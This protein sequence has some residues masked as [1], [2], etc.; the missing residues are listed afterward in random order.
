MIFKQDSVASLFGINNSVSIEPFKEAANVIDSYNEHIKNNT[1]TAENWNTILNQCDDTLAEH[2]EHIK[3]FE[4]T[5]TGYT[6]SLQGGIVG[7]NKVNAAIQQYNSL[8][9]SS[10]NEQQDLINT[11]TVTNSKLGV[12]LSGLNGANAS[13]AGYGLSLLTSTAKT[14]GLTIATTALNAALTMGISVIVTGAITAFTSWINASK[15]ITKNAQAA[16]DKIAS[17]TSDL[18]A[19]TETVENSK[20]RYA[21]L[22][23]E[24]ENLG[25]V[26]QSQGNLS[27]DEYKEFLDISNQL[28]GVF[29]SLTKGYDDNGNAILDLSGNVDTIVGSLDDLLQKEKELANKQIIDQI[30]NVYKDYDKNVKN[31]TQNVKIAQDQFDRINEAYSNLDHGQSIQM[32][33][34][35]SG[36]NKDSGI[37]IGQYEAW[38]DSLGLVYKETIV[39]G[40]RIVSAV[41]D[42]DQAF[43][44][45]LESARSELQYAKQQLDAE[46][47]S[48]GSYLNTWL[49]SDFSYNQI[50][51][52]GL[53]TAVKDIITNFD[54]TNLP[55]DVDSK[56]WDDVSEYLK[57][58]II[59]AISNLQNNPEIANALSQ[60]FTNTELMPDEKDAYL[61]KIT[62]YFGENNPVTSS[63]QPQV[64]EVSRL[65]AAYDGLISEFDDQS[66]LKRFLESNSINTQEEI[67]Y[68]KKVTK[69]AKTTTEAIRAYTKA[70]DASNKKPFSTSEM[71]SGINGLSEGFEELDKIMTSMK[72]KDKKFDYSLLDDKKFKDN[73][74]GYTKE[75]DTFIKTITKN[76]KDIKA[77]Q[78]AFDNLANAFV[79]GS[80]VMEHLSDDNA[81]VAKQYLELMGIQNADEVVTA[82]LAQRHAE[83]A[84]DSQDLTN[85]TYDEIV[86]L[87]KEKESTEAG[88]KAFELYIAQKLLSNAAIDPTGDI[89]ALVS[90]IE[91]LG[92][93]S[94]AWKNYYAAKREQESLSSAEIITGV[95]G[96]QIKKVTT[97]D[98]GN[99]L[100]HRDG[101]YYSADGTEY[102]GSTKSN[103]YSQKS[104]NWLDQKTDVYYE[105]VAKELEAKAKNVQVSNYT[106]PKSTN[107]QKGSKGSK[108]AKENSTID[109]IKRSAELLERESTRLQTAIDDTWQ[110][111]T[112]LSQADIERVQEL[113]NMN[114]APNSDEVN[115]LLDYADKL[116]VSIGELQNLANNNG[117]ESRQSLLEQLIDVDKQRLDQGIDSLNYYKNSYE[118]YVAKVPEYRDKIENGGIDIES[119]S[120]DEKTNIENAMNAYNSYL[121]Q[122]KTNLELS[123]TIRDNELKY[124]TIAIDEID[125]K[126]ARLSNSNDLIQK[127]I[128]LLNTQGVTVSSS[129]Y[130]QLISNTEGQIGY[131]QE[132]LQKQKDQ[133]VKAITEEDLKVGSDKWYELNDEI[134]STE[135]SIKDLEKAQAEYEKQLRELPI[136]NLE[137]LGTIYQNI[138]D[139]IQNWGSEMEASGKKLNADY[140]QKLINSADESISNYK[141]E[142]EAIQD[143]MSDYDPGTDNWNEMNDKLQQCNSSISSLVQNMH[144]WNEELL[145]LPIDKI[146]DAS[147]SLSKIV[148]GLND[149]KSEHETVIS[150]VTGAISDEIDRLNDEKEAYE[151]TINDQKEALQDRMDL[152]D[153]QNEKLKLQAQYE[154]ALY[155]LEN[156]TTQK[157]E[158]VIRNGEIT[159]ESN[160]DNLR[161]AQESV[162]DALAALKKQELQDQMD[163]LDDALDDYNDKLQDT[164]D[165]LQKISDKWSEIASK[166]EQQVNET[167]ATDILGKGWK[168]K[169]LSGN[170]ADIF[171]MFSKLYSDNVDQINKYQEQIDSTEHISSLIQEYIDSYKAGTLTYE[172]AQAGIHDLVSQMNQKMSAMDNLQNIYNYMG[173]VYDTAADGNS[174]FAGIQ[175]AFSESGNQL[176]SSLEQYQANAGLISESMSSWQQL[177]NN[178]ESIKD[179]LEDV[180]DNLKDTERDSDS[181]KD[182]DENVRGSGNSRATG[183][184]S[185]KSVYGSSGFSAEK[186]HSGVFSGAVGSSSADKTDKIKVLEAEKLEPNEVPALLERG[187]MV[188]TPEQMEKLVASFS[189]TAY[190]PDNSWIKNMY[191]SAT[192]NTKPNIVNVSVGDVKLTDVRDVD[193]FAKAMG[194]DFVPLARQALARF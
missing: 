2:L 101:K 144:K 90:I 48:I 193:G 105:E 15:E 10:K 177:T 83:A 126:N 7:Y 183:K 80:G 194:R 79:Y 14:I 37:S 68:F 136:T 39:E 181:K 20:Q 168:D 174:V 129:M 59:F 115:E 125:K 50:D 171:Q 117:L 118:E 109:W 69:S 42:I 70:K 172:E 67:N 123:N 54:F 135:G 162:Q 120:G 114:L 146:S 160:A 35:Y 157:T 185:S 5:M 88:Q 56:N 190:V 81:D 49:Q 108:G 127:Q 169:V 170:D 96:E 137:K 87:A 104:E 40:G 21:E 63:L 3:G 1:L 149:V 97:D 192:V 18:K 25:K 158:K 140:Y 17:I 86:A 131:Q 65:K 165:S 12:Y 154:Q 130:D 55:D 22:A 152:L 53:Q 71:I 61:S 29:P 31:A 179:I 23:Q 139:T 52:S 138:L 19:N 4:T 161:N 85:A 73:F 164:L 46:K 34:D 51:D 150:A 167:T 82:A 64:D 38:L 141:E 58:N 159:Y 110:A 113:F 173:K 57:R 107:P 124:Y 60:V 11:I 89:S 76:P 122:K 142:I 78:D 44:E 133:L 95:N 143:V 189:A 84:Y 176:I 24:V 27:N 99:L 134:M 36:S 6:T 93:A 91:S 187:E 45:K 30:P 116:G 28:A 26:N 16:K 74:G 47:S 151:D 92:L 13:L 156:A 145:K 155:D 103:L 166:K 184:H 77:C 188:F 72:D 153:K 182:K 121:D 41:G 33:F 119:F 98:K 147:D 175:K 163:A 75:Y 102:K 43:T 32:G 132:K 9:G 8:I 180:K 178:V 128:D 66:R 94:D 191:P 106:G 148:D 112:G 62:S 111:Y 100:T 186:H